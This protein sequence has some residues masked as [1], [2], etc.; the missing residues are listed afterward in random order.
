MKTK[1]GVCYLKTN[2]LSLSHFSLDQLSSES[3][4]K[5]DGPLNEGRGF[6]IPGYR[7]SMC[8]FEHS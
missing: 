3:R 2:F 4:Q 6:H 1:T 5:H 8:P 7:G